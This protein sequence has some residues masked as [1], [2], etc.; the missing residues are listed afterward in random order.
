MVCLTWL[1]A[2]TII[3]HTVG[4]TYLAYA[5]LLPV[6][7]F[8]TIALLAMNLA[9]AHIRRIGDTR[10]FVLSG[11]V[12]LAVGLAIIPVARYTGSAWLIAGVLA[13]GTVGQFIVLKLRTL[14]QTTD[15]GCI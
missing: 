12:G 4:E 13:G 10:V 6:I 11:L 7:M 15:T 5:S 3:R 2:G 8:H 14:P 9:G 1:F